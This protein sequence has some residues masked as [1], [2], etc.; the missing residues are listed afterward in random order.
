MRPQ[1]K[2]T[3]ILIAK[4]GAA[5]GVRGE[6]RLWTYTEEPLKVAGYGALESGDGA[7]RFAITKLRAAKT[8]L[9]ATIDGIA[10]R[11]AAEALN[12]TEL[13]VPRDRLPAT[14]ADEFYHADLVGLAAVTAAHEAVGTVI[15]VHNF[16]GGDIIEIAPANGRSLMLPFSGAFVASIDLAARKIVVVRPTEIEGEMLPEQEASDGP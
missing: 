5:H 4:I 3:V 8:H 12:G 6:V 16:G 2:S 11:E 15:A 10:T 7:R 1:Q 13:F 14:A 9:V